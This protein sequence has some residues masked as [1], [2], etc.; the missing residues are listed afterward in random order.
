MI[1]RDEVFARWN[2]LAAGSCELLGVDLELDL[3]LNLE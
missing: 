1:G 3:A 2:F